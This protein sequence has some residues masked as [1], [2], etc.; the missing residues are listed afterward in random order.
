MRHH[1]FVDIMCSLICCLVLFLIIGLPL[2]LTTCNFDVNG[3]S[4]KCVAYNVFD[5][6]IYK[7]YLKEKNCKT[8][9]SKS[10]G[11]TVAIN[12]ITKNVMI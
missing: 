4:T 5:G 6:Y 1:V 12:I 11:K 9:C 3:Y 8:Y 7:T 10:C 2:F